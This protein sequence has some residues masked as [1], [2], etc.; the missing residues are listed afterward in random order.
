M[1]SSILCRLFLFKIFLLQ[2]LALYV[3]Y[4]GENYDQFPNLTNDLLAIGWISKD[5]NVKNV[6]LNYWNKRPFFMS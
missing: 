1:V 2:Q 5:E 6:I 4:E 3:Y